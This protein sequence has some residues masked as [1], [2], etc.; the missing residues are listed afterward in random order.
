MN[1][2]LQPTYEVHC[3][4]CEQPYLGLGQA[5]SQAV[6]VLKRDGWRV[7]NKLWH[8]EDCAKEKGNG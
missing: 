1:G 6:S 7:L 2:E 8:C 3:A 4:A 5:R